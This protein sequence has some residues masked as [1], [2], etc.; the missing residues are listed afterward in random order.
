MA[1]KERI[2]REKRIDNKLKDLEKRIEALEK[3]KPVKK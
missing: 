1:T 3:A 2:K